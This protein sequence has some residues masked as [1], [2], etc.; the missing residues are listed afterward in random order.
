M[1][2]EL[3]EILN[4]HISVF[5]FILTE[6]T[7]WEEY[8]GANGDVKRGLIVRCGYRQCVELRPFARVLCTS[9]IV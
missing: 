8:D 1:L 9:P 2:C 5:N 7:I 6:R 3:G 4:V